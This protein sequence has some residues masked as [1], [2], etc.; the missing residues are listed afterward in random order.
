MNYKSMEPMIRV[1]MYGAD[2]YTL[3]Y[4]LELVN[5]F[6]LC[7]R[8]EFAITAIEPCELSQRDYAKLATIT[9]DHQL[10]LVSDA[11]KTDPLG[12]KICALLA[13]RLVGLHLPPNAPISVESTLKH[14]SS[15]QNLSSEK[16][17]AQI[18]EDLTAVIKGEK[19]A[20]HFLHDYLNMESVKPFTYPNRLKAVSYAEAQTTCTS[21]IVIQQGNTEAYFVVNATKPLDFLETVL[22]LLKK[23]SLISDEVRIG[24]N[25]L[26][27]AGTNN[28]QK[29]L[30]PREVL[31]CLQRHL[32]ALMD[33]ETHDKESGLPHIG[34]VMANAMFY[35]YFT[36]V[37]PEKAR[38]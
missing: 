12:Q 34:H 31:E 35:S 20:Q 17:N 15:D 36:E 37:H 2:K 27:I 33:G 16:K 28:W 21:I 19:T 3:K 38:E 9:A 29:G 8:Q 23:L 4:E 24:N 7:Q 25:Q 6:Q 10:P 26:Q 30:A 32:A 13:T 11:G 22:Q 1:L 5:L 18:R 14:I